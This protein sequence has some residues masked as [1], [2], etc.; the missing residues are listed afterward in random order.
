MFVLFGFLFVL[1]GCRF[2]LWQLANRVHIWS[3]ISK[4][5]RK[6]GGGRV[7]AEG[8]RLAEKETAI[9]FGA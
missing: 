1:F 9:I 4:L 8:N 6:I 2:W 3:L 7:R 5:C